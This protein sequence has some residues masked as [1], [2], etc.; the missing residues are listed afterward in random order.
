MGIHPDSTTMT[1][2][3]CCTF[4]TANLLHNLKVIKNQAPGARI[5]A[6]VKANAYGHGLV[7]VS[8]RLEGHVDALGVASIHEAMELYQAGIKTPITLIEGVFEPDELLLAS[9]YGFSVVFH[10]VDQI[11]WLEEKKLPY[12]LYAWLKIDTGMDRLGFS[13][14]D[15]TDRHGITAKQAMK[16]LLENPSIDKENG[17]GII[18]HFACANIPD[19]PMNEI[20]IDVF[21]KF[22]QDY[23]D[24][25][26]SFCNSA[27]V[28]SFP[29]VHYQWIRPGLALFGVS[30]LMKK[31]ADNLGLLP[32]MTFQSEIIAIHILKNGEPLGYYPQFTNDS[33]KEMK[34]AVVAAGYGDGYPVVLIHDK[35]NKPRVLVHTMDDSKKYLCPV[36]GEVMMDMIF[37]D[38]SDCPK[39]TIK[40]RNTVTLWGKDL[41]IEELAATSY[42]SSY[43][44]L[45][46]I[47]SRVRSEWMDG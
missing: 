14:N 1:R 19:D 22:A 41:P 20:Q 31:T 24:C 5:M 11:T 45:T 4:S 39:N 37:I 42:S 13:T 43:A 6:M 26:K 17:V 27:A 32:V 46:D 9:L 12:P 3:T 28:F 38:I 47:H 16:R 18:S 40:K 21:C 7:Q 30:P 35:K 10:D 34:I 25:E 15:E 8:K 29:D 33:G 44:L 23:S 2:N 36:I